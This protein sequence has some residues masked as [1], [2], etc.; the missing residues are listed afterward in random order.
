MKWFLT[1]AMA[2]TCTAAM[3]QD[4]F[5]EGRQISFDATPRMVNGTFMVPMRP[6][7]EAMDVKMRRKNGEVEGQRGRHRIAVEVNNRQA[8]NGD[9]LVVL[10]EAPFIWKGRTY[11]PLKSIAEAMGYSISHEKGNFILTL[12]R[13]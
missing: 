6:L 10:D 2:A 7:F 11:A 3:S 8:R 5:V 4:V 13:K 12:N 9:K 1:L